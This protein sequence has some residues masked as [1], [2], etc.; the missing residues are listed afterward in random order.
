MSKY[1]P[2]FHLGRSRRAWLTALPAAALLFAACGDSGD[3]KKTF[4]PSELTVT[5]QDAKLAL[6]STSGC[7]IDSDCAAGNF[8]FQGKCAA[9]CASDESCGEGERCSAQG[10]CISESKENKRRTARSGS[11]AA[12]ALADEANAAVAAE[13]PTVKVIELPSESIEVEEGAE[14]ARVSIKTDRAVPD[15]ALLYRVEADGLGANVAKRAV[16]ED[17]FVFELPAGRAALAGDEARLQQVNL[18]T[19]VGGWLINVI[20]R[21]KTSGVYEGAVELDQFGG[22]KL[23]LKMALE[24]APQ[25][26]ATLEEVTSI[27]V[28]LPASLES[29]FSPESVG[30]DASAERW[31]RLAMKKEQALNCASGKPCFSASFSTNDFH[32]GTSEIFGANRINRTVRIEIAALDLA[33]KRVQGHLRDTW[34]GLFRAT[35]AGANLSWSDVTAEGDFLLARVEGL[36]GLTAEDHVPAVADGALG[37][38]GEALS[39]ARCEL[40]DA[41]DPAET[42]CPASLEELTSASAAELTIC[43][44]D[45]AAKLL[46]SGALTSDIILAYMEDDPASKPEDLTFAEFLEKCAK[47][48]G[49]CEDDPAFVCAGEIAAR[50]YQLSG[51]EGVSAQTL[52][53][54][55]QALAREAYLGRQLAA[56]QNDV[57]ARIGWLQSSEVPSIL[58]SAFQTYND[59]LLADWETNVLDAHFSVLGAQFSQHAMEVLARASNDADIQAMRATI[60][61]DQS[62]S[63]EGAMESLQLATTRWNELYQSAT[64]RAAKAQRVR[65]RMIDLYTS[66]VILGHLN[67]LADNSAANATFGTG[68]T[69]LLS[70]LQEL[71]L[72]FN[73]LI[74]LRDAE[75][76]VPRSVDPLSNSNTLLSERRT[77]ALAAV[78]GA[79]AAIKSVLDAYQA[80]QVSQATLANEM[81]TQLEELAGELVNL[82]GL[83]VGCTVEKFRR[84]ECD[85]SVAIGQCGFLYDPGKS[86]EAAYGDYDAMAAS[87]SIGEAGQSILSWRQAILDQKAA[88]EEFRVYQERVQ[89]H[90]ETANAYAADIA[91]WDAQRRAANSEIQN[92][93]DEIDALE[94]AQFQEEKASISQMIQARS[95]AYD[96]QKTSVEKW[97]E[98][99]VEG[100]VHDYGELIKISALESTASVLGTTADTVDKFADATAEAFPMVVGLS[101][102]AFSAAR[103]AVYF[104]AY[105][106]SSALRFSANVLEM[107]AAGV[108]DALERDQA[109]R[110]AELENLADLADL[111]A[112]YTENQLN[113]LA[114]RLR[115]KE[116]D[117]EIE[118][119]NLEA[120]ID[121][122]KRNLEL[123]L[124]HEKELARLRERQTELKSMIAE[125]QTYAI[126]NKR[127][128]IAAI[129]AFNEYLGVVQRAELLKARY[130]ALASRYQNLQ[131]LLTSP[132]VIFSFANRLESA[133][134]KL[135]SAK[136]R[137]YDWLAAIEY[138]AVRPFIDQRQAILLARNTTQL[139]AIADDLDRL[140]D[141]CGGN[142]NKGSVVLSVRDDLLKVGFDT[143]V[144]TAAERFRA[145][146]DQGSIP[147]DTLIRYSS[148]QNIGS[149]IASGR[150]KATSFSLDLSS[151][152]NL[153]NTCNAKIDSIE[154]KLVGQGLNKSASG[155]LRPTVSFIY[156]GTSQLRSC[157]PN[158][159]KLVSVLTPGSTNYGS[160]TRL[161]T[162]GRT[163]SPVAGVNE[164]TTASATV[165]TANYGLQGLPL[166]TTYSLLIDPTVGENKNVDWSKLDDIELRIN[167]AYQDFFPSESTCN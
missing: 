135:E 23:P 29:L 66:A 30:V 124:T 12:Q 146:L 113:D 17:S 13:V 39:L 142:I 128:E 77:K 9:E 120:L 68:F 51:G 25:Y 95:A 60:L 109:L 50:A 40:T 110:E 134:S 80:Q 163:V 126:A 166:A 34:K 148:D 138:Y 63:W 145:I 132:A 86:G 65:T 21:V 156:D 87:T 1:F 43:A 47:K 41:Y 26:A 114:D 2:L 115:Q 112:L 164:F 158:I 75:V 151:F 16:G 97:D 160:V 123:D 32:Q 107:S 150:A 127:A 118:V 49:Y 165:D 70:A 167:W 144:L 18:V 154:I 155:S 117:S 4:T 59:K 136:T 147:A 90:Y 119:G 149:V 35:S 72:S 57:T 69:S 62:S 22:A 111:N 64:E 122:L 3:E 125:A 105:A 76:V 129:Q 108:A 36:A 81:Q 52:M 67:K 100:A 162:E 33:N 85:V 92:Y 11:S 93:L 99:R 131:N 74:F 96:Q 98:I 91:R 27:Q 31:V 37:D 78:T 140:I 7:L 56:F 61:Q 153:A 54:N 10:R 83:P 14:L 42:G 71:S 104:G 45:M 19:S 20:P 152:A 159:D 94:L 102:D 55:W 24:V 82:C 58:A 53:K 161:K 116:I 44:N 5:A 48:D 133:E 157:Q 143:E 88:E 141:S 121:A 8:C 79:S 46:T 137:L 28:S 89:L 38:L 101:N 130:D 139:E 6:S 15:G 103:G 73:D 84:G 106:A